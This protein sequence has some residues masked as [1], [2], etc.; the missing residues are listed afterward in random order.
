[1]ET[2]TYTKTHPDG[3]KEQVA[4]ERWGWAAIYHPTEA[5]L[6]EAKRLTILQTRD[7]NAQIIEL[8]KQHDAATDDATKAQLEAQI[9]DLKVAKEVGVQPE[10]SGIQQFAE[11]GT[12]NGIEAVEQDRV[13]LFVLYRLD[14]PSKRI[15]LVVPRGVRLIHKYRKVRPYYMQEFLT[16]YVFGYQIGDIYHYNYV[17]PDDRIVQGVADAKQRKAELQ[18][19][20]DK[21]VERKVALSKA[22]KVDEAEVERLEALIADY[23]ELKLKP[24]DPAID[25]TRFELHRGLVE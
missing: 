20:I 7:I 11:D 18:A 23:R 2:I 17:L 8:S 12:F 14:D 6:E 21:M 5:Q 15:D 24:H 1:M 10:Q 22:E 19:E 9:A 25:L 13:S 4:P 16:V 3:S